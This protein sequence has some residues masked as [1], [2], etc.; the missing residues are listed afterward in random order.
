MSRKNKRA[1]RRPVPESKGGIK[2]EVF[3]IVLLALAVYVG[4]TLYSKGETANWGGV[5]G[6]MLSWGLKTSIGYAS[7]TF[8]FFLALLSLRFLLRRVFKVSA[9]APL[10][11][12]IFIHQ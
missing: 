4:L 6:D 3:G 9:I 1:A 8:P 11:F 5:V 7:Y 10:G 2:Q 12:I